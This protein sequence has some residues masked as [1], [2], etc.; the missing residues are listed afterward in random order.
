MEAFFK[1]VDEGRL[2]NM[3]EAE[4]DAF[5]VAHGFQHIGPST[6]DSSKKPQMTAPYQRAF[7]SADEHHFMSAGS[8]GNKPS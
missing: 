8:N 3:T 6:G 1:A 7:E 4:K 5:R 2:Q